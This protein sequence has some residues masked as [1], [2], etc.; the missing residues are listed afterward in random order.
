MKS[1]MILLTIFFI[2]NLVLYLEL[3]PTYTDGGLQQPAS[4]GVNFA[5]SYCLRVFKIK[6]K[7][8]IITFLKQI[9]KVKPIKYKPWIFLICYCN[10]QFSQDKFASASSNVCYS[11]KTQN[12]ETKKRKLIYKILCY[13][14]DSQSFLPVNLQ[15]FMLQSMYVCYSTIQW[16]KVISMYHMQKKAK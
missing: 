15:D 1:W 3:W 7:R 2:N 5:N 8:I 10:H 13:N 14:L 4:M 12:Q 11:T 16:L 9:H 6:K